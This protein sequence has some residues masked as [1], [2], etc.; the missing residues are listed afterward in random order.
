MNAPACRRALALVLLGAC[1]SP[2]Q[3]HGFAGGG[4]IHP[5]TGVDHMLAMVA[6][7]LWS[8]QLG[9]R[10]LVAVPMTFVAAMAVGALAALLPLTLPAVE[11]LIALSVL[12]V[13]AT[14]AVRSR[15][16]WPFAAAAALLF[17]LVHGHAHGSEMP[18]AGQLAYAAGFL[19]TT[20]GLHVAG[21]VGGLLLLDSPQGARVLRAG[22]ML[23][24]T[25]GV[26]LLQ[27]AAA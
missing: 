6:V 10:A 14:I 8:A 3:A 24:A 26:V 5:L 23:V 17:G 4:W 22:G 27:G 2:C 18:A 9:G 21:A 11:A 7:G 20:A 19:L 15:L 13:G 1:A 12:V 16:A 25:A